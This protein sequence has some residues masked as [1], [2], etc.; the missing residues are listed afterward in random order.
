MVQTL[1]F[2]GI[3][4]KNRH[5]TYIMVKNLCLRKS[6]RKPNKCKKVCGCK[7]ASGSKRSYCRKAKNHTKKKATKKTKTQKKR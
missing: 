7:V 3:A 1:I 2:G 6:V 5:I 4:K